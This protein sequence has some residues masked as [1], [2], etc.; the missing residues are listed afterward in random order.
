M[1]RKVIKQGNGTLTITLPKGWTKKEDVEGGDEID[2]KEMGKYLIVGE[3]KQHGKEKISIDIS[4]LDRTTIHILIQGI[5]RFGYDV[6]EIISKDTSVPHY[7]TG[8]KVNLPELIYNTSNRLVG[9][10]VISSSPKRYVIKRLA[11]ESFDDFPTILRRIFL[12][13]NEITDSFMAGAKGDAESL[14]TIEVQHNNLKKF[15][16]FSLR[17][18]NKFGYEEPKKTSFYFNIISLLSKVED[19]IKNNA[20]YLLKHNIKLNSKHGLKL[21]DEI[22][23]S[24]R[25][26]YELFYS[27][28]LKKIAEL[29]KARDLFRND[30]FQLKN[31]SKEECMIIGAMSQIIELILDLSETRVALE[32]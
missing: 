13:L 8:K 29:N 31:L 18:L 22:Q 30:L 5:Y 24:I 11:E 28:D 25:L 14:K 12:L 23:K 10:E 27:Y 4:G 7:R 2:I 32:D 17:L 6:I 16:N 21:L 1:K 3:H 9:S 26:F 19:I 20:R 15:I